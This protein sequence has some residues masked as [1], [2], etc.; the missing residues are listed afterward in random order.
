MTLVVLEAVHSEFLPG[1]LGIEPAPVPMPDAVT[2]LYGPA[3]AMYAAGLF[4]GAA[5]LIWS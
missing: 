5:S 1:A 2:A 4:G 3:L